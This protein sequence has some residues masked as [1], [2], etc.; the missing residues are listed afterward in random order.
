MEKAAF[1]VLKKKIPEGK[2]A[3]PIAVEI[4]IRN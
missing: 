3:K 1:E 4:S 2:E